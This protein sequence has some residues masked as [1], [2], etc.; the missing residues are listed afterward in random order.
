MIA[1]EWQ[2]QEPIGSSCR[3]E[4][5]WAMTEQVQ[6]PAC[7]Q[8]SYLEEAENVKALGGYFSVPTTS[9]G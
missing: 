2:G 4:D 8:H 6:L 7:P 5:L 3:L 1:A 9:Y